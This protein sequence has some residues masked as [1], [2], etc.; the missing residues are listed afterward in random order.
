MYEGTYVNR[1]I[2]SGEIRKVIKKYSPVTDRYFQYIEISQFWNRDQGYQ[3]HYVFIPPQIYK[4]I[5][6]ILQVG[7]YIYIEG[8]FRYYDFVNKEGNKVRR[9]Y[10]DAQRLIMP[11]G[12]DIAKDR[13][14]QL[15]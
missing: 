13:I 15:K 3:F 7:Q 8:H 2:V 5:G 4:V 10:I 14:K 6:D 11:D 9:Y 12:R 1:V